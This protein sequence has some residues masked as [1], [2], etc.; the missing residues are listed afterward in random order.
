MCCCISQ[1]SLQKWKNAVTSNKLRFISH[2]IFNCIVCVS[3]KER[4]ANLMQLIIYCS[5]I[6]S[7]ILSLSFFLIRIELYAGVSYSSC[8]DISWKLFAM[9]LV[10]TN[11]FS[12]FM[13]NTT[14]VLMMLESYTKIIIGWPHESTIERK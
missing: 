2:S 8:R 7:N 13:L 5:I 4:N 11:P 1:T 10:K 14:K 3:K 12:Q 6:Q 9:R